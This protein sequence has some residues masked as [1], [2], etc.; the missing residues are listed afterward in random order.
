MDYLRFNSGTQSKLRQCFDLLSR[1]DKVQLLVLSLFQLASNIFDL[2]AMALISFLGTIISLPVG[3]SSKVERKLGPLN[4]S[5]FSQKDLLLT[6]SVGIVLLLIIKTLMSILITKRALNFLSSRGSLISSLMLRD[7]L[8]SSLHIVQKSSSQE[9]IFAMTRGIEIVVLHIIGTIFIVLSDIYLLLLLCIGL[10][11]VDLLSTLSLATVF[12]ISGVA[13]YVFMKKS[14]TKM[15]Q[16]SSTLSIKSNKRL[17]E[18]I[19]LFREIFVQNKVEYYVRDFAGLRSELA[20]VQAGISFL[21]YISKY[22]IETV[23]ILS[24]VTIGLTQY[25]SGSDEKTLGTIGVFLLAGLR[26]SP[27]VLRIQQGAIQIKGSLGMV[28]PS[29]NLLSE[30]ELAQKERI[31]RREFSNKQEFYGNVTCTDLSYS[32]PNT[33]QM[34]FSDLTFG[35]SAGTFVGICGPSGSG[36]STLLDVLLG[37]LKPTSGCVEISGLHPSEVYSRFQGS[38][39]YVPQDVILIEGSILENICIGHSDSD[40]DFDHLFRVLNVVKLSSFVESLD[41][42]IHTQVGERGVLISGGQ[43]QRIGLA[44]ALYNNPKLLFLDES[45]SALDSETENEVLKHIKHSFSDMT[46]VLV[47]HRISALED[48]DQIFYFDNAGIFRSNTSG[49]ITEKIPEADLFTTSKDPFEE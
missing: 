29:L 6:V 27:A 43:K 9:T 12:G 35:I 16:S 7:L 5:E 45:T 19:N 4:F 25:L 33:D 32:Y 18:S 21:P 48:A 39:A 40:V 8:S 15:G 2:L 49:F 13:L 31:L 14:V 28:T 10:G 26:I 24:A 34:I 17:F 47:T 44:R 46:L 3:E 38:V 37:I 23:L 42:K 41:L 30:L 11:Y 1:K 20:K 36:K 22:V